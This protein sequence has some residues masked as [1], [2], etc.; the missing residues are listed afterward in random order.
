MHN[1]LETVDRL[2]KI[3]KLSSIACAIAGGIL[4]A[5]NLD[6]SK[7]GF[8][9]LAMSSCQMLVASIRISDRPTIIYSASLF[10]FVDSF[11]IYRWILQSN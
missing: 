4:L 10:I 7:Y 6:I 2:A 1:S 11:G 5:A 3:L 8:V 9:L